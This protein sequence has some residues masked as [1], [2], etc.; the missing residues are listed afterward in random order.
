MS[1]ILGLFFLLQM[2]EI[3]ALMLISLMMICDEYE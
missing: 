1:R 3:N 2:S